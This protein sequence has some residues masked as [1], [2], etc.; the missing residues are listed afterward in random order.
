LESGYT[1]EQLLDRFLEASVFESGLAERTLS[2]Y[3]GDLHRYIAFLEVN[4]VLLPRQL[5]REDIVDH[6]GE[7]QAA[8]QAPRSIARRLSAIRRFHRYLDDEGHCPGNPAE[9]LE[10]PRLGR[11]LPK[12][13]TG[14]EV[15]ALLDSPDPDT[16]E[17]LRDRAILEVF[18]AC[19][20]RLSELA[21]LPVQSVSLEESAV[22]V[23]GKGSKVRLVPL[24]RRAMARIAAYLP[25]RNGGPILDDALFLSK[26]GKRLGRVLIWSI[27]KRS[28][29][30]ANIRVNVTP[31]MLRHSFATHMLDHGADLRAV[32]EMLG[33]ADIAT[34]QIYT[35]V[36]TERLKQ[37]HQQF[38]PRG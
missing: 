5:V 31:H 32:Q 37:A 2:A 28:A 17:G 26:R 9:I 6:L 4:G 38:H 16:P 3:A 21:A 13:L 36:S 14:P 15:D 19:G 33:H 7:M 25:V 22:R 30:R 12:V 29:Q 8:G 27:V 10:S 11:Q 1:W 23:R 24:G 34:T 18:Y 20:L 35:H